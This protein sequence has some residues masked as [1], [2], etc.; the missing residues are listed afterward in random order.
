MK[1][2]YKQVL[3][4]EINY[5]KKIQYICKIILLYSAE[6]I[7]YFIKTIEKCIWEDINKYYNYLGHS[8]SP[9]TET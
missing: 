3:N 9:S 8:L 6:M 4:C 2:K 5:E 1:Y 7:K